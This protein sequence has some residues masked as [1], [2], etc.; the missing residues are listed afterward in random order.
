MHTNE[1]PNLELH[2]PTAVRVCS[3]HTRAHTHRCLTVDVGESVKPF[4]MTRCNVAGAIGEQGGFMRWWTRLMVRRAV[5]VASV[6]F[7]LPFLIARESE[8]A[9]EE[10]VARM[11]ACLS[12]CTRHPSQPSMPSVCWPFD[13]HHLVRFCRCRCDGPSRVLKRTL[14]CSDGCMSVGCQ[15]W[16][17]R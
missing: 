10:S 17:V 1:I 15:R 9:R 16:D 7:G 4:T 14:E 3:S 8:W 6:G 5:S 11:L 12:M 2:T 13:D